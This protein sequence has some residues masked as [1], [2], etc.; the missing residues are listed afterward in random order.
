LNEGG[1]SY[2]YS[3]KTLLTGF[4]PWD[5]HEVNP[6]GVVALALGGAVLPVDFAKA[7]TEMRRLV[8]KQQPD[9]LLM[10]GLAP[11][12]TKV[13]LEAVAMNVDH[14]EE[15]GPHYRWRKP[16]RKGS[17]LA[18]ESRLPL[19]LIQ[20]R[21][22]AARLPSVVSHHA[23]TF[24]CNHVF[25]LGLTLM[26]GPCGFVHLPPFK[27]LSQPRQIQAIRTILHALAGSSPGATR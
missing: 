6:S 2:N 14:C 4:A 7:A 11:T 23:G 10:L 16:I 26:D 18:L 13:A 19:T 20:R 27:A 21:L 8:R 25:Y 9:A 12:R 22:K 24:L 5:H 15:K 3:V 17:P 1:P